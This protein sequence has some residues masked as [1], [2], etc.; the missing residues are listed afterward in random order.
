MVKIFVTGDNHIGRKYDRYPEIKAKLIESRFECLQDMVRKA[1]EEGCDFFVVTGDLFDNI[2]SIKAGDVKKVVK[3]LAAFNSRV[4]VLPGNHDYY[5]GDDK[6]WRDFENALSSTDHNITVL[7]EFKQ[8]TFDDVGDKDIIIYPAFCHSKHSEENNLG[9]IKNT[10]ID[11]DA[12]V[13]IGIAHGALKG[14]TPDLKEE[15]FLM[16]E[17]ELNSIPVDVWLIGH[18]HIAY[19]GN[20]D[21]IE[22]TTGYKIFNAGTHEQTDLSNNSEGDCFIIRIEKE[23]ERATVYAKKYISGKIR[24]FD[25][26]V[27]LAA[28]K[29]LKESL[30]KAVG[31]YATNSVIRV[32]LSGTVSKE[33]YED[34]KKIYDE[35]LG[36][37]LTFE[38]NDDELSEEITIEKIRSDFAETSFA[39]QFLEQLI[40][41]PTELQMAYKMLQECIE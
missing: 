14:I 9:W 19:P 5:T 17:E 33:D 18:T 12:S 20:L 34:R 40:D 15:Y 16:S 10:E 24:Y 25:I 21:E 2:N 32:T 3:I 7:N 30:V 8:Y 35:L 27:Q 26:K 29:D 41:E 13:N 31:G 1:E 39:A 23:H 38:V 37:Y 4:L 11:A 28:G 6:V 36:K 22:E